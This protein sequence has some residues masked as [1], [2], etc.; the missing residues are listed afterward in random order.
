MAATA[1]FSK[2]D[3]FDPDLDNREIYC[4]RLEHCFTAGNIDETN[5]D[6]KRATMLSEMGRK[7][8]TLVKTKANVY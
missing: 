3:E 1:S 8:Y 5:T 2:I 4:E 6:H 7:A